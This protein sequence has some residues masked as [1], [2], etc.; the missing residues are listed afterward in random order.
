MK[1]EKKNFHLKDK[2]FI[3]WVENIFFIFQTKTK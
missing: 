2:Q 1:R 3:P